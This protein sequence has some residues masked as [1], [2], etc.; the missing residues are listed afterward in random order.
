M[1]NALRA[2][3]RKSFVVTL[4]V[5]A[6][7]VGFVGHRVMS[8]SPAGRQAATAAPTKLDASDLLKIAVAAQ[9]GIFLQFD[10]VTGLPAAQHAGHATIS[11]MQFG[12][13]RGASISGGIRTVSKP[14]VSEIT[15]TH[16]ADKYSVPF[17]N[18]S[19]R[20]SGSGNAVIYFTKL[21]DL[22]KGVNYIEFDLE[23]ALIT[24]YSASAGSPE[25]PTE[26]ISLN[27]TKI[28]MTAQFGASQT[29]SYDL[30]AE[31]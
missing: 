5:A 31:T 11:S 23:G 6:L 19:L 29:V 28:T 3:I 2:S 18:E 16:A 21:N 30:L 10:G 8:G 24:S 14:T 9:A 15:L 26:A 12:V 7:G 17:L 22:G 27:F 13:G 4:T 20:G 25:A 1:D